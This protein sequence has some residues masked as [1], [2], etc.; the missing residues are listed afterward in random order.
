MIKAE[1]ISK[2]IQVGDKTEHIN[3]Y[4]FRVKTKYHYGYCGKK[5][6]RQEYFAFYFKRY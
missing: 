5:R 3:G 4:F 2:N 1:H 6:V